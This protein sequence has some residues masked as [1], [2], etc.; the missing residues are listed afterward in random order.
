MR[1]TICAAAKAQEANEPAEQRIVDDA[2]LDS[3]VRSQRF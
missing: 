2:V 3:Y 1:V